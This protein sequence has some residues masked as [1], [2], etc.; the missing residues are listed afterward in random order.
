MQS[1]M[2]VSASNSAISPNKATSTPGRAHNTLGNKRHADA[3]DERLAMYDISVS[4]GARITTNHVR[5][6]R[7]CTGYAND[8]GAGVYPALLHW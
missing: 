5:F 8:M 7:G 4:L 1:A 6:S 2:F 3:S